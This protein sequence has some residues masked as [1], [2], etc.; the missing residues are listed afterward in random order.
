MTTVNM[1]EAES[2]LSQLVGE[3]E[4]GGEVIL[5]RDGRPVARIVPYEAPRPE[6]RFGAMRGRVWVDDAFLEPLP[7]EEMAGWE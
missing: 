6:R 7:P 4:R 1:H 3:V 5:A 2:R